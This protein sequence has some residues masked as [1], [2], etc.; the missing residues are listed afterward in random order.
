MTSHEVSHSGG[1][2]VEASDLNEEGLKRAAAD[3]GG[4]R[5]IAST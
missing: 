2:I 4:G 5:R 1:E 3:F